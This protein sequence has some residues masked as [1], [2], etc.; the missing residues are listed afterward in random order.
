[1]LKFPPLPIFH[2]NQVLLTGL[3]GRYRGHCSGQKKSYWIASLLVGEAVD[4]GRE[5][6]GGG[7][8]PR[9]Q[10]YH[11][12][13]AARGGAGG[14]GPGGDALRVERGLDDVGGRRR[15]SLGNVGV[16]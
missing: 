11:S 15:R 13:L 8:Q 3:L 5:R 4:V 12:V 16:L 7:Q 9:R 10:L 1:M 2:R 14:G 6:D